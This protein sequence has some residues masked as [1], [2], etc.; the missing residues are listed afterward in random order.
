ML[1]YFT[2]FCFSQVFL[3]Y[4]FHY[5]QVFLDWVVILDLIVSM[6]TI[7]THCSPEMRM[8]WESKIN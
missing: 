4:L 1:L 5:I 2:V 8:K 3:Y 6:F 7:G